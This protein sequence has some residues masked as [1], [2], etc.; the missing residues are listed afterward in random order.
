[1]SYSKLQRSY[2]KPRGHSSAVA[3]VLYTRGVDK[4]EVTKSGSHIYY[5]DASS[6]PQWE[7]RI[8]LRV[9]AAGTDP[10]KCAEA[11]SRVVYGLRGDAFIVA[12]EV[13][14]GSPWEPGQEF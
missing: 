3:S 6:Y 8:R 4:H 11:V 12:R 7:F 10:E 2:N 14:S 1:M 5:G 13:D 9:K